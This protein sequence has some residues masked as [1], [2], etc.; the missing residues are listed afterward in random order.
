MK[1]P[2]GTLGI[3][4]EPEASVKPAICCAEPILMTISAPVSGLRPSLSSALTLTVAVPGT[5]AWFVRLKLTTRALSASLMP[6]NS[7][8]SV[9]F[10]R[11]WTCAWTPARSPGSRCTSKCITITD[12]PGGTVM[13]QS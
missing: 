3:V 4:T 1:L 13:F 9:W 5:V 6:V 11:A 2:T 7:S 10:S 12:S 8:G